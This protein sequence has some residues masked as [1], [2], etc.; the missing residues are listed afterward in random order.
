MNFLTSYKNIFKTLQ[1]SGDILGIFLKQKF[2][3]CFS[4]V[5]ETLLC[6]YWNLPKDQHSLSSNRTLLIQKQLFHR[7]FL[8]KYFPLT[9]SPNV[10]L[11]PG[12]LKR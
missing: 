11:M 5:L 10:P 12:T 2:L 3:Q 9:C 8:K 6:D 7:E 1:Y 4:N